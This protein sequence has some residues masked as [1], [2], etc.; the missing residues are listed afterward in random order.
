MTAAPSERFWDEAATGRFVLQHSL[1]TGRVVQY[2]RAISP[3]GL[4][5]E[6]EWREVSP[7]ATVVASTAVH[8]HTD[9]TL[10]GQAPFGLAIVEVASATAAGP[11]A[12]FV[13]RFDPAACLVPGDAVILAVDTAARVVSAVPATALA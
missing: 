11:G 3:Y 7:E 12:R 5:D 8:A 2:P 10:D 1:A 9:P 6:L 4:A 13:V